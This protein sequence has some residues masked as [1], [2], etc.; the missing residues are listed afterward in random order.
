MGLHC[1]VAEPSG[2]LRLNGAGYPAILTMLFPVKK[3]R[4]IDTWDAIGLRG[5][6]S[7]SYSVDELFLPDAFTGTREEPALRRD[8]GSL[9]AFPMQGL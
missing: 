3:A 1:Q 6:V 5:T 4:L 8:R 9:Y 7:D 2:E